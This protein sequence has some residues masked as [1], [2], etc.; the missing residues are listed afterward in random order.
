MDGQGHT[1]V[2]TATEAKMAVKTPSNQFDHLPNPPSTQQAGEN[3]QA[4]GRDGAS[5]ST[6]TR[7]TSNRDGDIQPSELDGI[8]KGSGPPPTPPFSARPIRT[9]RNP[10]PLYVDSIAGAWSASK[11]ELA[12]INHSI[13][14][15]GGNAVVLR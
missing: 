11:A 12:A 9:T 8:L 6:S 10:A 7:E 13:S 1:D 5:L 15:S 2:K 14:N 3:K 4:V